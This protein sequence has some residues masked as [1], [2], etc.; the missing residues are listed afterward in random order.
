MTYKFINH[1]LFEKYVP[2]NGLSNILYVKNHLDRDWYNFCDLKQKFTDCFWALTNSNK[3][4]LGISS[5]ITMLFPNQFYVYQIKYET[6]EEK[7]NISQLLG[8]VITNSV[9][10]NDSS[11]EFITRKQF[12][13]TLYNKSYISAEES[14][15]FAINGSIPSIFYDY[16]KTQ[17]EANL[18]NDCMKFSE[19]LYL[20]D[21][22][23]VKNIFDNILKTD[24]D[25]FF[26]EA[27]KFEA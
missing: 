27:I 8:K 16:Y 24:I 3:K 23:F 20:K 4:I 22:D 25:S 2:E 5:D 17:D 26:S 9:S 10:Y 14:V 19:L 12:S 13:L 1:G 7:D 6:D 11:P 15:N 18:I 21:D